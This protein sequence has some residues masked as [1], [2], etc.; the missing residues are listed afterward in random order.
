MGEPPVQGHTVEILSLV[1]GESEKPVAM[2]TI[3]IDPETNLR[4]VT[5]FLGQE[6]AVFVRDVLNSY[7]NNPNCWLYMPKEI[8]QALAME[9]AV[10]TC[11]DDDLSDIPVDDDDLSDIVGDEPEG[12]E[13]S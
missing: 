4:A 6:Q 7:L 9:E 13:E 11:T 12:E 3:R 8:Q 10:A 2:L 1:P 5:L